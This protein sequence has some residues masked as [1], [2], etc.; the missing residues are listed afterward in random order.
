MKNTKKSFLMAI[1][2]MVVMAIVSFT[3]L[4]ELNLSSA[5]IILGIVFFFVCK[6]IER[7][8]MQGSGLDFKAIGGGLKDK[9]I[10]IWLVLP[11]VMGAVCVLLSVLFVPEY[12]RYETLRA[13]AFVKIEISVKSFIMF[14]VFALGEEIA[15]RA[16]FQNRLSKVLPIIPT[17]LVTSF[18]FTLGHYKQ[19]DM[20][21]VLFGL[22]FTLINSVLYGVV[23]HKSKN[24]WISTISHFAANIFQVVLIV[25][26]TKGQ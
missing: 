4:F 26:I 11:I 17:V 12:I 22:V 18:L 21:V 15:W 6:A 8:P 25:L 20:A 23:F 14:L 13:G 16:F 10:W 1:V 24:S 9:K 2:I 19:G 5:A 7:Q 3:N